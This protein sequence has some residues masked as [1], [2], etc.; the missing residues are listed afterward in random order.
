MSCI[1]ARIFN[2]YGPYETNPHLIP[3]IM[4]SL[5]QGSAV[6]LGNVHTK[7]DYVYV[8]DVAGLLWRC[9]QP[10]NGPYTVVNVGTGT[11]YSAADIVRTIGGLLGREIAI[12][13]DA[14]RVRVVD[15]PHQ[16]AD[17]SR[18][19]RL[20]GM[21]PVHS[22]ADGLRRLLL[23]EGIEVESGRGLGLT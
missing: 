15:K 20:T 4:E 21:R 10:R 13:I 14:S 23:H 16:R 5:R 18:L 11:E 3:H 17:T 1:A 9:A 12:G 7:R 22:L 8:D 6:Q 19:E 2:A